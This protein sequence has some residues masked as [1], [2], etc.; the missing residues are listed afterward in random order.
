MDKFD[1]WVMGV[2]VASFSALTFWAVSLGV[3]AIAA[4]SGATAGATFIIAVA[5]WV[6]D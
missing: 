5:G 4:I 2:A 6:F 1:N 3:A